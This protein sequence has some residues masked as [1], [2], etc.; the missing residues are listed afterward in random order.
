MAQI[1]FYVKPNEAA[2]VQEVWRL[3]KHYHVDHPELS[4]AAA[5]LALLQLGTQAAQAQQP[6]ARS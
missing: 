1:N 6:K 4:Q 5:L 3:V 2:T